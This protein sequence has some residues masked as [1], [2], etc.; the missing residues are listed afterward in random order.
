MR[1]FKIGCIVL[2]SIAIAVVSHLFLKEA[3][4]QYQAYVDRLMF[5]PQIKIFVTYYKPYE[6]SY[7]VLKDSQFMIPIQV[8]RAIE[9]E[10]FMGGKLSEKDISWLHERMIGDDT[11]DNI[12]AKN[13]EYDVLTAYYWV[14]KHY[15]E[16]GN[17]KYIGFAA[18]RK[19]LALNPS[20]YRLFQGILDE[21]SASVYQNILEKHKVITFD[22]GFELYNHYKAHH[23]ISDLD[24]MI[25]VIKQE[26]PEMSK[27]AD[28]VLYDKEKKHS[29]W[30]F[31]IMEKELAFDYFEKLF[32]VMSKVEKEIGEEVKQRDFSTRRVYGHLAERFFVI[33]LEYQIKQKEIT[34][35]YTDYKMWTWIQ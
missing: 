30:N 22:G 21:R 1:K 24:V 18:H 25:K 13:R 6:D 33:W 15:K 32:H 27:V 35:F 23:I 4:P 9:K 17:P 3:F 31:W 8:G 11:G 34:P 10:P 26:Y 19:W 28:E 20:G 16:I 5:H 12:S 29:I 2:L 7:N 14:W